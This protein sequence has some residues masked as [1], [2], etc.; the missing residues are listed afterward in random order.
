MNE[1][2]VQ[3][4]LQVL[5]ARF[6]AHPERHGGLDWERVAAALKTGPNSLEVLRRMEDTGGEPDVVGLDGKSGKILFC[7]CSP[8]SPEGRRSLCYDRPAWESRKKNRPTG[9]VLDA[10]AALGVELLDE[11]QYRDLQSKGEF[12]LKTSSWI[13][14]TESVR[15]LGG[16]LFADRR[17]GRVFV[18]HNG[19]DSYYSSRGFRG[20]FRV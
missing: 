16:A 11:E 1:S 9:N 14:A 13:R 20:I 5:K 8:E 7:D 3:E 19:A 6:E 2:Q 10:A 4:I 17:Y 15:A 18:Y 12:D